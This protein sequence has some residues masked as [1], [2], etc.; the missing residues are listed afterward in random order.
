MYTPIVVI[1]EIQGI[2]TIILHFSDR[3]FYTKTIIWAHFKSCRMVDFK[4][5]GKYF[6]SFILHL[7]SLGHFGVLS[8]IFH[9]TLFFIN[10]PL[11]LKNHCLFC[12]LFF[13]QS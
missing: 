3:Y 6:K 13:A 1:V 5:H 12:F 9:M 8:L 7:N 2:S 10:L 4:L 11:S